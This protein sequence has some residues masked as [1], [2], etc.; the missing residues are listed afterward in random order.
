[1][2]PQSPRICALIVTYQPDMDLLQRMIQALAPQVE[3]VLLVD[4]GSGTGFQNLRET[5]SELPLTQIPLGRNLGLALAQNRGVEWARKQGFSH[6][7]LFDQD[8]LVE[9]DMVFALMQGLA[10]LQARGERVAAVGP[11]Y[12]DPRTLASRP[13]VRFPGLRVE[14]QNCGDSDNLVPV[15]FLIA[16]GTLIPLENIDPIGPFEDDLF[17]DNVDLEWSFRALDRGF[18]LYG[19][20]G[21][22]MHHYLGDHAVRVWLGRWWHVYRHSPL[23]QYYMARNR[24]ILYRRDYS[25]RGWVAQ[26]LLRFLAKLVWF[27]VIFAPRL[28]NLRMI[29]HG[30]LDGYRGR[31]GPYPGR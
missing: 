31:L 14:R 17:I 16:S 11:V 2:N 22:R 5:L 18:R 25:P 21:A 13:F 4:N 7:L 19:V 24:V 30:M 9:P 26:D 23:R 20:C 3:R 8:S 15:D 29:L 27:G 12:I 6:V 28:Q 1:M 10:Q